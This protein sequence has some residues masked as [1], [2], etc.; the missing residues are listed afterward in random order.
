[1]P[2][3][4]DVSPDGEEVT[5]HVAGRFD[6][7]S[8]REFLEVHRTHVG[9]KRRFVVDMGRAVSMDS[10]ALGMLLLLREGA[11]SDGTNVRITNC[12]E[13]LRNLLCVARF[14]AIFQID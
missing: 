5:I 2:L 3:S 14:D 4:A 6:F 8:H 12:A 7:T 9:R 11:E 13:E 1:M 10:S